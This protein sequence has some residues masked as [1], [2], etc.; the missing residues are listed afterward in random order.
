MFWERFGSKLQSSLCGAF[1][2]TLPVHTGWQ[3]ENS[4]PE[5]LDGFIHLMIRLATL[6]IF[7][8]IYY[9]LC[10]WTYGKLYSS[11]VSFYPLSSQDCRQMNLSMNM[12]LHHVC[13]VNVVLIPSVYNTGLSVS[14]GIFIPTLLAG[15]AWG[16]FLGAALEE[17]PLLSTQN[18][19]TC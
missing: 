18:P 16:R 7:F 19:Q 2:M 10:C 17:V 15:A 13:T 12:P 4:L 6:G 9:L 3:R 5:I 1:S 8:V 11:P 14:S